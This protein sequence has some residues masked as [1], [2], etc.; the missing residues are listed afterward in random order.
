M[1]RDAASI[2]LLLKRGRSNRLVRKQTSV[3]YGA[4]NAGNV[5]FCIFFFLIWR[6][7]ARKGGA[8]ITCGKKET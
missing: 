3:L 5:V 8:A 7:P 1:A 4:P 2:I 6:V